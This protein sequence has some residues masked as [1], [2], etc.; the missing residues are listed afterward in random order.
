MELKEFKNPGTC[1]PDVSS[2]RKEEQRK[3]AEQTKTPEDP[4]EALRAKFSGK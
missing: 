1:L 3:Q 2:L 4:I